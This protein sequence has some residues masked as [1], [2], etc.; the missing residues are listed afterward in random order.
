VEKNILYVYVQALHSN[1]PLISSIGAFPDKYH[2]LYP[3]YETKRRLAK[4]PS[5]WDRSTAT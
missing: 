4:L 5:D 3:E 1:P 2:N